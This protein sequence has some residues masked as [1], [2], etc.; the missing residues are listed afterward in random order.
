MRVGWAAVVALIVIGVLVVGALA[1]ALPTEATRRGVLAALDRVRLQGDDESPQARHEAAM[2]RRAEVTE[3][4]RSRL[5]TGTAASETDQVM[6]RLAEGR[7]DVL[8]VQASAITP[9]P[10]ATLDDQVMSI[11]TYEVDAAL[12]GETVVLR[13]DPSAPAGRP[14]QVCHQGQLIGGMVDANRLDAAARA[15]I[16][17]VATGLAVGFPVLAIVVWGL[18][19]PPA[20]T[21]LADAAAPDRLDPVAKVN[22]VEIDLLVGIDRSRDTLLENT[23]HFARGLPANNALLWG[24]RGMGKSSLVKA[25]HAAVNQ[26]T[27]GDDLRGEVMGAGVT[28]RGIGDGKIVSP[29]GVDVEA[30]DDRELVATAVAQPTDRLLTHPPRPRKKKRR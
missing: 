18:V 17:T 27:G 28:G 25:A 14:V 4:V 30:D 15:R 26:E 20:A 2:K 24:A 29:A 7:V 16:S 3:E 5:G 23:R 9:L 19:G 13:Y 12:V 22:R 8:L 21:P 11:D 1:I 6:R 10:G